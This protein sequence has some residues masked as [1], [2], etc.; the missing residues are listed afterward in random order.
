MNSFKNDGLVDAFN[1]FTIGALRIAEAF[2][3][4]LHKND[5]SSLFKIPPFSNEPNV[6]I[7]YLNVI[8][9]LSTN[10]LPKPVPGLIADSKP[11]P[12]P[13]CFSV[14]DAPSSGNIL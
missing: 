3:L 9:S 4:S 12:P 13:I 7:T 10:A 5:N 2:C 8:L 11:F 14:C 1:S 6:S